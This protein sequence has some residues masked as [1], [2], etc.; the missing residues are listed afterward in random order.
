MIIRLD[1]VPVRPRVRRPDAAFVGR[2]HRFD[3]ISG[4]IIVGGPGV[5]RERNF[6]RIAPSIGIEVKH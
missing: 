5:Y 4:D 6:V 3:L 2:R 1:P